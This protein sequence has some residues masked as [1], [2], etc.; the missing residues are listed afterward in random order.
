MTSTLY[1]LKNTTKR[2]TNIMQHED[3]ITF[4]AIDFS[5]PEVNWFSTHVTSSP[6]TYYLKECLINGTTWG[7]VTIH[8]FLLKK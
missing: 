2:I 3:I 7:S 6:Q 1:R 8:T 5:I 4:D